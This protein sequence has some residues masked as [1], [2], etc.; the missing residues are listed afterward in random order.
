VEYYRPLGEAPRVI[1]ETESYA[2]LYKPPLMFSAPLGSALEATLLGWYGRRCPAVL[3]S[4][5]G[6]KGEGGILHRL[7][8]E[9]EGLVLFAKTQAAYES[10]TAQQRAGEFVKE[11]LAAASPGGPAGGEGRALPGF[12]PPPG[13]GP[14][15]ESF[16]RPWGPGRRA[17][18]PVTAARIPALGK[19]IAG[20]Q[21]NCYRTE[22][23]AVTGFPP[24]SEGRE[25]GGAGRRDVHIFNLRIRRGFRHQIRCHLA[26]IG[27]PILYDTLYGWE[28]RPASPIPPLL[29][30]EKKHPIALR[31]L[32][33]NFFDPDTGEPRGCRLPGF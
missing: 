5:G 24:E 17:V 33:V 30:D 26:W 11:Y 31:A 32:A 1:D 2:V 7:D 10:L 19:R 23:L 14:A 6:R 8:F 20:D 3:D 12:P 15:I 28:G 18:R 4:M 9:T 27:E 16:F 21:G 25:N 13:P 22:L 29:G